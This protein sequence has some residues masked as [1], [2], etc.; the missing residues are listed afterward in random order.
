MSFTLVLSCFYAVHHGLDG[1]ACPPCPPPG[2]PATGSGRCNRPRT[3]KDKEKALALSAFGPM[4][5]LAQQQ[6]SKC[7]CTERSVQT[8]RWFDCRRQWT[9]QSPKD[10]KRQRKSTRFECFWPYEWT[11]PTA[12]EQMYLH[13]AQRADRKVVRLPQA[14]DDAI[15][16]GH[17]KTKKKHSL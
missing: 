1:G 13:K 10:T 14:V 5:G 15:V 8:E 4:S 12:S 16:Q 7:I 11:R 17:E 9:I 6:A 2:S 3:R